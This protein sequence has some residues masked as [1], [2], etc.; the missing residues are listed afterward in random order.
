VTTDS[1]PLWLYSLDEADSRDNASW[2]PAPLVITITHPMQGAS[3]T[4][5]DGFQLY[6]TTVHW[7]VP[8]Y[9]PPRSES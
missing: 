5:S 2:K 9:D 3:S 6:R 4:S 1:S 7:R 8:H